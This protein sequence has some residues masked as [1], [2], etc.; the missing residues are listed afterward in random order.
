MSSGVI[1]MPSRLRDEVGGRWFGSWTM[2]ALCMPGGLLVL[3]SDLIAASPQGLVRWLMTWGIAT[4]FDALFLWLLQRTI[5]RRRVERPWPIA[6]VIVAGGIFGVLYGL[7]LYAAS[8]LTGVESAAPWGLRIIALGA[9]GVWFVPLVSAALALASSERT[10]RRDDLEA[11][12]D[13]ELVRLQEMSVARDLRDELRR[14]VVDAL[15]PLR[16]RVDTAIGQLERGGSL[17][18]R[19]LAAELRTGATES[20]RPLS[21]DLER[22][23]AE[24]YPRTPWE[25]FF[26]HTARTQPLRPLLLVTIG[27]IGDGIFVLARRGI[28]EGL[29][30]VVLTTMAVVAAA[31]TA[32]A[33]MG[34]FPRQHAALFFAGSAAI[35]GV[36]LVGIAYQQSV[37]GGSAY[38]H[39]LAAAAASVAVGL[40]V[41]FITSGFGSWRSE[42]EAMRSAFRASVDAEF[43][44]TCARGRQLA[45][46]ARDAARVLHGSVQSRLVACAMTIDRAVASGDRA[47]LL[48]ALASAREALEE[49]LPERAIVAGSIADEVRRKVSLWGDA[50]DFSITVAPQVAEAGVD[51]LIVGRVVEEGLTNAIRHGEATTIDVVIEADR[52][53]VLVTVTDDGV[54]PGSVSAGLGSALLDQVTGGTWSLARVDGRTALTAV[55][56]AGIPVDGAGRSAYAVGRSPRRST[57]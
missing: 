10:R 57:E 56:P 15:D 30:Y 43:V 26:I 51:P 13:I 41:I 35:I 45:D 1:D 9:I 31:V 23:A 28:A 25:Q 46:I 5:L 44:A 54:G 32:N 8:L 12:V 2:W 16:V 36:G 53:G 48:T 27:L 6:A 37:W 40:L 11:L 52:Q 55:I 3:T 20:V 21:H 14:G 38:P 7:C 4:A 49:P 42:M 50:C 18:T 39:P 33:L 17:A 29:P 47:T 19:L 22:A 34:R 24:R